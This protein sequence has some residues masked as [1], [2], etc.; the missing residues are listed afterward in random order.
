MLKP[1]TFQWKKVEWNWNSNW[2][3]KCQPIA[4]GNIFKLGHFIILPWGMDIRK[5]GSFV[6]SSMG[7]L[8]A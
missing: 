5:N 7:G 3:K 4:S 8:T 1:Q 6:H 2:C